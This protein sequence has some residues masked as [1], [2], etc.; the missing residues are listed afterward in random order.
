MV[1]DRDRAFGSAQWLMTEYQCEC[2]AAEN[3]MRLFASEKFGHK[4][5]TPAGAPNL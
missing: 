5:Q 2:S 4:I 1:I 3:R